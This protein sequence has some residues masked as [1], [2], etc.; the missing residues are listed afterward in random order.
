MP[1]REDIERFTHVLNSLG[2]EPALRAARSETI[3]ESPTPPEEPLQE[4]PQGAGAPGGE[5]G[6]QVE[7][8]AGSEDQAGF[9]DLFEGLSAIPDAGGQEPAAEDA[10]GAPGSQGAEAGGPGAEGLDFGSLFAD[11][12]EPSAIDD[13]EQAIKKLEANPS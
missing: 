1:R 2:D 7:D 8:L 11:E 9:Q 6:E 4:P 5:A 12:A 13:L 3:E 10:A